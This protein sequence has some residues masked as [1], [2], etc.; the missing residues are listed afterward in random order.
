MYIEVYSY[1]KLGDK[2][3]TSTW[4]K[5]KKYKTIERDYEVTNATKSILK[6]TTK[7]VLFNIYERK[8]VQIPDS[9]I[10]IYGQEDVDVLTDVNSRLFYDKSIDYSHNYTFNIHF[11]DLDSND[12]VNNINYID[13]VC[14]AIYRILKTPVLIKTFNIIYKKEITIMNEE[15]CVSLNMRDEY[16]NFKIIDSYNLFSYGSLTYYK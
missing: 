14:T 5:R 12:H 15:I 2:I 10:S 13:Y 6:A 9:I 8:I 7:W 1:P 11:L 4:C 16:C 3:T